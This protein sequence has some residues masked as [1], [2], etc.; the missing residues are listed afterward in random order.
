[1][2]FNTLLKNLSGEVNT[3]Y[4]IASYLGA[5]T[6]TLSGEGIHSIVYK[7][8]LCFHTGRVIIAPT[9]SLTDDNVTFNLVEPFM[10]SGTSSMEMLLEAIFTKGVK[11][12][13]VTIIMEEDDG[14]LFLVADLPQHKG[15]YAKGLTAGVTNLQ[16]LADGL[17]NDIYNYKIIAQ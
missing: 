12:G 5:N 1:M 2:S 4:Q 14:G 6:A 10:A 11:I 9:I 17:L 16:E 3:P 15:I 8:E 13:C 7:S